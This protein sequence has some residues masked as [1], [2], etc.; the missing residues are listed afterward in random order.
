[1]TPP[2]YR[3]NQGFSLIELLVAL[4]INLVIVS[5]AAY[6]YL[7]TA[8]SKRVL[9]QQQA[10]NENG[11]AALDLIGRDIVNAGFFPAVRSTN[12]LASSITVR[13]RP[14]GYT[15]VVAAQPAAYNS[16]VFGCSGQKF[17]GV[18]NVCEAHS[19]A[20]ITADT[21]VV[22]YFTNDSMGLDVG[23][24]IDCTRA[25]VAGAAENLTRASS[26]LGQ[27][28]KAPMLIS[29]RYSLS[30]TTFSIENQNIATLSLNCGGNNGQ[31]P[32]PSIAGIEELQFRYGVF[33][34]SA[35]LQ[36][37]RFYVASE[38]ASLVDVNVDG[39]NKN[40]WGRVVSVE[41]CLVA[42]ALQATKLTDTAGAVTPYVNCAG[43]S[44]TPND[45]L[46]RRTYRKIFA[47]RNNLTQNI[48][49]SA[50]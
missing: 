33:T 8:D 40:A 11:Q 7:G 29:N 46:A 9:S 10:L 38:M 19:T 37:S 6:L 48:I 35:T 50:Q 49:P 30:S 21:I 42:R 17:N 12:P 3:R 15:N 26:V 34:D 1:M 27:A 4:A 20:T 45:K 28:P 32:Q 43:S 22:N 31:I 2:K 41:V 47:M 5:A 24:R 39:V 14:D 16:G 44:V 13:V 25:D 18:T 23:Q 36:P